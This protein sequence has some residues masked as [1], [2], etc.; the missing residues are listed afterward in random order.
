M[1]ATSELP[2][3][4]DR[5]PGATATGQTAQGSRREREPSRVPLGPLLR[6]FTFTEV[7][8]RRRLKPPA[9]SSTRTATRDA[10]HERRT[11][12]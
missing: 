2:W 9:D 12:R 1:A 7:F 4:Q 5:V 8:L 6:S 10:L 3:A 11:T